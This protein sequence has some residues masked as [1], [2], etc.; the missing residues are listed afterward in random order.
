MHVPA[1]HPEWLVKFWLTTP[2]I[3]KLE[4]HLTSFL[5]VSVLIVFLVFKFRKRKAALVQPDS[6]EQRFQRLIK[7]KSLIERKLQELEQE[8]GTLTNEQYEKKKRELEKHLN[9]TAQELQQ[10]T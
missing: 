8:S 2:G 4:P 5:V 7:E 9:M 1:F 10:F 6:E 3:N